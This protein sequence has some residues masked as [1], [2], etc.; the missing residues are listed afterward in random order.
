MDLFK[1]LGTN[2]DISKGL[3]EN[4]KKYVCRLYGQLSV[5]T[6]NEARFCLFSI[7]KYKED[8]MPCTRDVLM[9]H[10]LRAV[11]QA[12][13]WKGALL[14]TLSA[15]SINDF[16][17]NVTD[18]GIVKVKWMTL[19]AA[20]DGILE[21][22]NCGCKSGC[23]SRRCACK[24]GKISNAHHFVPALTAQMNQTKMKLWKVKRIRTVMRMSS[25][26]TMMS[27]ETI[28][29][30]LPPHIFTVSTVQL[31]YWVGLYCATLATL[32]KIFMILQFFH[33]W[34]E[35][36]FPNFNDLKNKFIV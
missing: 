31:G 21:N 11:Y 32:K 2:F 8:T 28:E 23:S 18:D 27:L 9:Q 29:Q 15:P 12:S 20:P 34:I 19:P 6:V 17:W 5:D 33:Q 36:I 26:H 25:Q 16:C 35:C 1:S 13:I 3:L 10:T 7:G 4:D 30:N 22:V 14:Q 24:K